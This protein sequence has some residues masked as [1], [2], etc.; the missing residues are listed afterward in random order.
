MT[1]GIQFCTPMFGGGLF[2]PHFLSC[3][4]L[5]QSLLSGG[6]PHD[7]LTGTKES[8]VHRGRMEMTRSFLQTDFSHMMW[9][10]ADIE[11]DPSDVAKLWNM[12]IDIA[13]GLYCM[14]RSDLPLSAWLNG[15]L[16]SISDCPKEPFEVDYAGT[17]F[18][19]ISRKAIE[20][21]HRYL[22]DRYEKCSALISRLSSD[23]GPDERSL[24]DLMLEMV[25]PE[26]DGN[27][28]TVPA[29]YMTP[30]HNR[31]LESEDYHFCRIAQEAG[32]KVIADPSINLGHWGITRYGTP[33]KSA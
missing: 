12:Q 3:M 23:L 28:G 10:D 19:L 33:R 13:V 29:L 30:I 2:E 25:A 5:Q 4:A 14:K 9:I 21:T 17:G 22:I 11:F 15:K 31:C 8:L 18:M 6:L 27:N 26:Y 1:E 20:A 16:V 7:W 24:L 32:F